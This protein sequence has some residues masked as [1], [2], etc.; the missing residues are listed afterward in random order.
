MV[1]SGLLPFC[2]GDRWEGDEKEEIRPGVS[3]GS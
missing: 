1:E 2:S 3:E